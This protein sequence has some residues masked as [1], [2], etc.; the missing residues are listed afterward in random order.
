MRG[1]VRVE[2]QHG[3]RRGRRGAPAV[4]RHTRGG[5]KADDEDADDHG[6]S[7]GREVAGGR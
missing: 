7:D 1:Q 3:G 5:G 4:E 2:L 6:G